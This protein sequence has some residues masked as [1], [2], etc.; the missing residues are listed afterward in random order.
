ML[1]SEFGFPQKE[2]PIC[3]GVSAEDGPGVDELGGGRQ[4]LCLLSLVSSNWV[5]WSRRY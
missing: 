4:L 2:E 3:E 1:I 5:G